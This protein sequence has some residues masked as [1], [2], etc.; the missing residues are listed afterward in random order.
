MAKETVGEGKV[1]DPT[2]NR[3]DPSEGKNTFTWFPECAGGESITLLGDGKM[4]DGSSMSNPD[5]S[6]DGG[7]SFV[8]PIGSSSF[9]FI[10]TLSVIF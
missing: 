8:E 7:R 1:V 10:E 9:S 6:S 3:S 4:K 2:R 5:A